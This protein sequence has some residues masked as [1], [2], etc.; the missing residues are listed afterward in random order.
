MHEHHA[1]HSHDAT[2]DKALKISLAIVLVV[3]IASVESVSLY[4][5]MKISK[6]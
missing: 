6:S 2:G 3:M 5:M 1:G 4:G